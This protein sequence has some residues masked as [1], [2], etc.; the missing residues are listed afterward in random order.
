MLYVGLPELCATVQLWNTKKK[1]LW[2]NEN[3]QPYN[4][5]DLYKDK[6]PLKR[7]FVKSII[8]RN[9]INIEENTRN[10]GSFFKHSFI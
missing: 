10:K 7:W 9:F 4:E 1:K 2:T 5:L 8:T 6:R 3:I